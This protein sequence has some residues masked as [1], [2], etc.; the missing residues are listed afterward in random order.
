MIPVLRAEEMREADR[1]TIEEVGLPGALLMENAGAAVARVIEERFPEAR[2]PLVVCG[3][4][5]NGGDGFVVARRLL[6]RDPEVLL[7][8]PREDVTGEAALHLKAYEESGGRV[9]DASSEEAF[10]EAR[11]RVSRPTLVV[12]AVFGTGL[13]EPPSGVFAAAIE[14]MAAWSLGGAPVVAVDL[15]SGLFADS[16]ACE[17]PSVVARVTVAFAAPRPVHVLPPASDRVG[18]LVIADIGIPARILAEAKPQLFE[19]E[20]ADARRCFPPRPAPSHKGHFGHVLVIAGSSGKSGAAVLA[21]LGA[22]RAGAGL[23][24]LAVPAALVPVVAAARS[25]LMTEPLADGLGGVLSAQAV[26]RA[27][28]LARDRDAVVLGPGLGLDP[29]TREFVRTFVAQCPIPLVVDAD[30]LNALNA[31]GTLTGPLELMKRPHPTVVTPHPG[32][33]ARLASLDALKVQER[34]LETA[35]DFAAASGSVVV[36]KGQ[37][38][39]IAERGGRAAVNPTG[40]P[41]LAT[42]GTG[43]ILAGVIG[44]LLCRQ[45][46]FT[47]ATGGVYLHGLAGDL[48]AARRGQTGLLAG[49]VA[50]TLP[51]A[52]RFL[53]GEAGHR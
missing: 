39:V 17:G 35:R 11:E 24:T 15:P 46:P 45:D 34:R 44:A 21:A 12:D 31:A 41:G 5:K 53:G 23:V 33:M 38:T 9:T 52:I 25:E 4:G 3:K 42:G 40:N 1:R 27:L 14:Q 22:L 16:G 48:A 26:K 51:E 20:A 36:L 50:E 28:A 30:G 2:R 13:R 19:L 6:A 7:L 29:G 18:E 49:E 43:D 37:R 47:A 10:Q 32:E 8:C